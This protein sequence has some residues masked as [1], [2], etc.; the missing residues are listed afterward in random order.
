M[1]KI[2]DMTIQNEATVLPQSVVNSFSSD[3]ASTTPQSVTG[4]GFRP[5]NLVLTG[6]HTGFTGAM[7]VS[8]VQGTGTGADSIK[9]VASF[10]HETTNTWSPASGLTIVT[11]FSV[12]A[13]WSL[14]SYDSD[15]FT[16]TKWKTGS[17]TGNA[18]IAYMAFK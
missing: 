3:C 8:L 17:P 14:A 12:A 6:S 11:G 16:L 10:E 1:V 13:M 18:T 15:G 5:K 7:A 9:G 2:G 4:I